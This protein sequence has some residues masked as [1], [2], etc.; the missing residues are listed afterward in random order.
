MLLAALKKKMLDV[1]K[2][3]ELK[4]SMKNVE[5]VYGKMKKLLKISLMKW[6][7]SLI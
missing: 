6:A 1:Y 4:N 7:N 5:K 2:R 3:Q